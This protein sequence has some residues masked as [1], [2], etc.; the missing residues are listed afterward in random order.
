MKK[1]IAKSYNKIAHEY[2]QA[3]GYGEHVTLNSLKK[4]VKLLP[5]KAKILDVGCGGGQ[6]SKFLTEAG[7]AVLGVDVSK[8]MIKLAKR[9][10][11]KTTFA[12]AD[13]MSLPAKI[14]YNGI[15]CCRVFYHISIT[16]QG[17]FLKNKS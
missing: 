10:S 5:V 6:D 11:P 16:E 13:V 4:F 2:T 7:Y 14:K 3:H 12:V 15:W 8:E 9:Y 17:K 1:S